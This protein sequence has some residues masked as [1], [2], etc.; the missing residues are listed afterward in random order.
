MEYITCHIGGRLGNNLFMIANA[1]ARAPFAVVTDQSGLGLSY[2]V[3]NT[4]ITITNIGALSS[5][6]INYIVVANDL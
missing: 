5:T 2:T 3:S 1:Y 4:A 6:K